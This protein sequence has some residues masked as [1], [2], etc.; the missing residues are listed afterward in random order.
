ME[1]LVDLTSH[2]FS[3]QQPARNPDLNYDPDQPDRLSIDFADGA[4]VET[5]VAYPLGAPQ[6]PMTTDQL[7]AKFHA[8]TGR[9]AGAYIDL[10]GFGDSADICT[11]FREAAA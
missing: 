4:V 3:R 7:A 11:F 9:D 8:I 1:N 6:R 5:A 2:A 10:L